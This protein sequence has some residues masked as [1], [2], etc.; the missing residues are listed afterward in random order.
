MIHVWDDSA[1]G[2]EGTTVIVTNKCNHVAFVN[3]GQSRT[4]FLN[5][6]SDGQS[7]ISSPLGNLDQEL[8]IGNDPD[9]LHRQFIGYLDELRI[10]NLARTQEE[11]KGSMNTTL[12]GNEPGLVGYWNFDDGTAHD[13]SA[14]SNDGILVGSA[15]I[16]EIALPDTFIPSD[17]LPLD[18]AINPGEPF[19]LSISVRG[20]ETLHSFTFDLTFNPAALQALSVEKGPFFSGDGTDP[21][22]LETPKVNNEKG[23]ITNI[24]S[25][26][27]EDEGILDDAGVLAIVTFKAIQSG[28]SN[29]ALQNI[30]LLTP[31]G[32]KLPVS[33]RVDSV[34]IFPHGSIS[35]LV[36]DVEKE[37]PI[38]GAKIEV[39]RDGFLFGLVAYSDN[40][41][42]YTLAGIPVGNFDVTAS[43]FPYLHTTTKAHLKRG[44]I[45]SNINFGMKPIL[46]SDARDVGQ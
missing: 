22:S 14:H 24:Q 7:R 3:D 26:R 34:Y 16:I 20:I 1:N 40:E 25:R 4:I 29:I 41:G 44:E 17:A 2:F 19:A 23:I 31:D 42:K 33:T 11:I 32:E 15:Q 18:K 30:H 12:E 38:S 6:R 46:A 27:V 37:T 28:N 39:S 35:G 10:W 45:T 9:S 8:W 36:I 21:T 43:K 13:R 5:G